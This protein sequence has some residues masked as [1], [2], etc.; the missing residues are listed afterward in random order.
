MSGLSGIKAEILPLDWLGFSLLVMPEADLR[1]TRGAL[2]ADVTV[3]DI[4]LDFGLGAIKYTYTPW[5]AA[6]SRSG[7]GAV[8][9]TGP[10]VEK[11][12]RVA[13]MGDLA[14]GIGDLTVYA[15]GQIRV[16]VESGYWIPGMKAA[17]DFTPGG[18]NQVV[19][20]GLGGLMWQIDLGLTRPIT[21]VT[22][23][24]YNGDG[25]SREEARN[26]RTSYLAWTDSAASKASAAPPML[27]PGSF[28][29][30]GGMRQHYFG[31]ALN[32]IALDR[33]VLID[34]STVIGLDSGLI[35]G[36]AGLGV[37]FLRGTWLNLAWETWGSFYG[38]ADQPSELL[39]M[40]NRNRITLSVSTGF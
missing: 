37:E 33:Y 14:W 15:E 22:E 32:N 36:H 26:F 34:A 10:T 7:G 3:A 29:G 17:E 30:I 38:E 1:W 4:G 35:M 8:G 27:L 2:R 25:L 19:F 24:L 31:L 9:P 12:D 6:V 20:R 28:Y 13:F 16:G 39:L 40:A 18:R 5:T 23:Y 11:L 21:L